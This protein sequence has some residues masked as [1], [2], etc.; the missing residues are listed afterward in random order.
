VEGNEEKASTVRVMIVDE[1]ELFLYG[2]RMILS[3]SG[4]VSVVSESRYGLEA[5]VKY[6]ESQ[7]EVIIIG[8]NAPKYE[9]QETVQL[10][11]KES[12]EA[13]MLV[14]S[15]S[16][17]PFIEVIKSGAKGFLLKNVGLEVLMDGIKCVKTGKNFFLEDFIFMPMGEHEKSMKTPTGEE[18]KLSQREKEIL[19]LIMSGMRTNEI[20]E[21]LD[22][23]VGAVQYQIR[24]LLKKLHVKSRRE[25][26]I[27]AFREEYRQDE[28]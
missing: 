26:A 2:V 14:L 6:R 25:A 27:R 9:G 10:I 7:P 1:H 16:E 24:V 19:R 22:V 17:K 15:D 23:R 18:V 11:H 4:E 3:R 21:A 12:P 20:A 8:I 5:L 13:R 28:E